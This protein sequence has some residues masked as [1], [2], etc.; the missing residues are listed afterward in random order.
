MAPAF[1][2]VEVAAAPVLLPAPAPSS[3]QIGIELPSG[4]RLTVGSGIDADALG[5]IVA[6]L[7]R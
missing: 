3:D 6:A 5:R 2:E 4:I 1:A 7:H